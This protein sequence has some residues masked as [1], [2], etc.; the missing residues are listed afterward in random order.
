MRWRAAALKTQQTTTGKQTKPLRLVVLI[1]VS[2]WCHYNE[3]FW[4]TSPCG[5]VSVDKFRL[6][7]CI[8]IF[9]LTLNS[10]RFTPGSAD[11]QQHWMLLVCTVINKPNQT[12]FSCRRLSLSLGRGIYTHLLTYLYLTEF[13]CIESTC[14]CAASIFLSQCVKY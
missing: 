9:I 11:L 13:T 12:K 5:W 14:A 10:D 6:C 2:L 8:L 3:C 1:D 7:L 4:L